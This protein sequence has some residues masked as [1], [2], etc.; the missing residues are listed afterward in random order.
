[1]GPGMV[2]GWGT[3]IA[4]SQPPTD[5][6]TPG[7]PLPHPAGPDVD[8]RVYT[9]VEYGRGAQIRP[10]THF[11]LPDLRVPRYDRGL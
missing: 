6:T 3:G 9:L 1:M 10:T 2:V 8:A 4:P 5:R 11:I 7:T